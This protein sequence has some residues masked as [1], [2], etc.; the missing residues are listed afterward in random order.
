MKTGLR[1]E[2]HDIGPFE[3][4][5]VIALVVSIV[6]AVFIARGLRKLGNAFDDPWRRRLYLPLIWAGSGLSLF[7]GSMFLVQ[8]LYHLSHPNVESVG[9]F[10]W[11]G[12]LIP[13]AVAFLL[14]RREGLDKKA[15]QRAI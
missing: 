8:S 7:A 2:E 5:F 3:P 14:A 11:P 6:A 12:F 9:V 4:S 15:R 1:I 13:V 10:G